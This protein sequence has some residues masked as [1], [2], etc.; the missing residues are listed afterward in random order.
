MQ[1]RKAVEVID[2]EGG[3]GKR[4]YINIKKSSGCEIKEAQLCFNIYLEVLAQVL[5]TPVTLKNPSL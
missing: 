1:T 4:K 5:G 2:R 3:V